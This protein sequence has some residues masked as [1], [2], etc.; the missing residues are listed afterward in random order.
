MIFTWSSKNLCIIFEQWRI[1]GTFSLIMSLIAIVLLTAGYECLRQASRRYEQA[2]E[3]RISAFYAST[4]S[5]FNLRG[6]VY[7][8]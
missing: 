6:Q 3:A 5:E 7:C 8:H 4:P 1:T 2:L